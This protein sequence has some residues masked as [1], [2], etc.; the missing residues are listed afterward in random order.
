MD[1]ADR[2]VPRNELV[3]YLREKISEQRRIDASYASVD[4][5]G[6]T[7][8]SVPSSGDQKAG[9]TEIKLVLPPEPNSAKNTKGRPVRK[10]RHTTKVS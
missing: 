3:S 4:Q 1:A 7:A 6:G 9:E 8:Y 10:H 5:T 2:L